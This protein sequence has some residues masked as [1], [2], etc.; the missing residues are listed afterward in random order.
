MDRA[1][2]ALIEISRQILNHPEAEVLKCRDSVGQGNGAAALVKLEPQRA[3]L[4]TGSLMQAGIAAQ[5]FLALARQLAQ[6]RNVLRGFSGTIGAAVGQG[7]CFGK[8]AGNRSRAAGVFAGGNF[9]FNRFAPAAQHALQAGIKRRL[10][11]Q[12]GHF[13]QIKHIAQHGQTAV[14]FKAPVQQGGLAR[15]DQHGLNL[16]PC[17]SRHDVPRQPDEGEQVA[18]QRRRHQRQLGPRPIN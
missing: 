14:H 13:G 4:V 7:E 6:P 9:A 18:H 15:L 12:L 11:G 8:A 16:Q 2:P 17:G 10:I 1:K 5:T 3:R